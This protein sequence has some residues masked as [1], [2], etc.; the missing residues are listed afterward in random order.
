MISDEFWA[1]DYSVT[2]VNR[3]K[4][5]DDIMRSHEKI[6]E[7][8]EKARET[9]AEE[10]EDAADIAAAREARKEP[11]P[12]PFIIAIEG[13]DGAGKNTLKTALAE[14][15]N[16]S[17]VS[18]PR[19]GETWA[20][21][22]IQDALTAGDD[23]LK[24][25][26][27]TMATFFAADRAE[28]ADLLTVPGV[29]VIDRYIASSAAYLSAQ[30]GKDE[31]SWVERL[32]LDLMGLPKP[33]LHIF[34]DTPVDVAGCRIEKRGRDKDSFEKD[35]ELQARVREF[36]LRMVDGQW[37]SPW[38]VVSGDAGDVREVGDSPAQG[39]VVVDYSD[40]PYVV[41]PLED[42]LWD[43]YFRGSKFR[44]LDDENAY[45]E[46]TAYLTGGK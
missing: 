33:D 1:A 35:R 30:T 38:V 19:Y 39:G 22:T 9:L 13:I 2:N 20:A 8:V 16:A 6:R 46:E 34:V 40:A 24:K 37:L 29:I 21:G 7:K 18:F 45:E 43:E 10:I 3:W 44:R 32:E 25:H 36:Y 5:W 14:L 42:E 26:P 17:A 28:S 23:E 11:P 31:R 12:K 4:T 15:L 41:D 27:R